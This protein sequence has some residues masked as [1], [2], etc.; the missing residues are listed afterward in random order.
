MDR[1]QLMTVMWKVMAMHS[2]AGVYDWMLLMVV[3]MIGV[4]ESNWS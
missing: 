4:L 1:C 2:Y 3:V